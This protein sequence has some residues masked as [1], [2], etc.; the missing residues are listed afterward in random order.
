MDSAV[1]VGILIFAGLL[2]AAACSSKLAGWLNVPVLLVFLAIG[3]GVNWYGMVDM[4]VPTERGANILGSVALAFI[5][6]SGGFDTKWHSV[7]PIIGIGLVLASIGVLATAVLTGGFVWVL[8][9]GAMVPTMCFLLGSIVSSTDAAAVFAIF[10]SRGVGLR[11]RLKN[12]LEFESGSNDPMALFLTVFAMGMLTGGGGSF[13]SIIPAF[14]MKMSI[15]IAVGCAISAF[16]VW[17]FNRIDFDYDGLYYVLG[18]AGVLLSYA[19]AESLSGNGFI[20]VYASG[21]V[22][23]NVN[24]VYKNSMR[25]FHDAISWLM[26][27]LLFTTLGLLVPVH[28]FGTAWKVAV[29]T[30]LFLMFVARPIAVLACML[31]SK[32]SWKERWFVSWVGL[33]GG[34]PIM[35]ATI[36]LMVKGGADPEVQLIFTIVFMIVVLSV[37]VQGKTLMPVARAL[38]LDRPIRARLR[39]PLEF[40]YTGNLNSEM[41]EFDIEADSSCVGLKLTELDLPSGALVLLIRRGRGF[42]VPRGA[43]EIQAHDGLMIL[44]HEED[45]RKAGALLGVMPEFGRKV[46][47]T[48]RLR[49]MVRKIRGKGRGEA[50]EDLIDNEDD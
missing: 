25:R 6:F 1:L 27:V 14:F 8:M 44:G 20:A 49:A 47:L 13:W 12:L 19:G 32:F 30:V 36:P 38:R 33:R 17:L 46:S 40:D 41:Y 48:R 28:V 4:L 34:A 22:L 7:V 26:Q 29:P 39:V 35:L 31:G 2:L 42:V 18:I 50:D 43:T 15:G 5:L 23:G 16:I 21:M 9:G 37:L 45:L 11:E 24:F 10:R 3:I